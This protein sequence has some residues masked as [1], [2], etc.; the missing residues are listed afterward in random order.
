MSLSYYLFLRNFTFATVAFVQPSLIT[1]YVILYGIFGRCAITDTQILFV[2]VCAIYSILSLACAFTL[3]VLFFFAVF[4]AAV[5]WR[6]LCTHIESTMNMNLIIA[7]VRYFMH[8]TCYFQLNFGNF[9]CQCLIICWPVLLLL[10]RFPPACL[11]LYLSLFLRVFYFKFMCFLFRAMLLLLF[12]F[13]C[14]FDSV[15]HIFFT[16]GTCTHT[17]SRAREHINKQI[18][19]LF[20]D[21]FVYI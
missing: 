20:L 13:C 16:C 15:Y 8:L 21:V 19:I 14:S 18:W 2:H 4:A 1:I 3:T 5:L 12:F 17:H 6:G 10:F 11:P 9:I 7:Q